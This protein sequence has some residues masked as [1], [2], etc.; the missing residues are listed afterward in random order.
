M[1]RSIHLSNNQLISKYNVIIII[2]IKMSTCMLYR[3]YHAQGQLTHN[4][5]RSRAPSINRGDVVSIQIDTN[6]GEINFFKNNLLIKT[7][8]NL[9]DT[10][11][12]SGEGTDAGLRPFVSFGKRRD[13]V[14]FMGARTGCHNLQY[15]PADPFTRVSFEGIIE[16][17]CFNG[18]GIL[19]YST[20][21]YWRGN[22]VSGKQ[23]G[24]Q[25]WVQQKA[26]LSAV[27]NESAFQQQVQSQVASP[28]NAVSADSTSDVV[29]QA[30]PIAA[31][32]PI[33][34][35][36]AFLFKN[37][38]QVRELPGSKEAWCEA[39]G[40]T[41]LNLTSI[42]SIRS[43]NLPSPQLSSSQPLRAVSN[44]SFGMSALFGESSPG[45]AVLAAQASDMTISSPAN[46]D[47][48]NSGSVKPAVVTTPNPF[49]SEPER[50]FQS[51][52]SRADEVLARITAMQIIDSENANTSQPQLTASSS[53]SS[54]ESLITSENPII[55]P[56]ES[57]DYDEFV[58]SQMETN[59]RYMFLFNSYKGG[60]GPTVSE[61]FTVAS[62]GRG[63]ILGSRGFSTGIHYWEVK[64]NLA[65]I[66]DSYG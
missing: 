1:V 46:I 2:L 21:G 32:T 24:I 62:H 38:E 43:N 64:L 66:N 4:S 17:G 18:P 48:V 37:G 20:P 5:H 27:N 29:A 22:W 54:S 14:I 11:C 34:T 23:H 42:G 7:F 26:S 12:L 31:V 25:L 49:A 30:S 56:S 41:D 44:E 60:N 50:W 40:F 51:E 33:F 19:R 45:A 59:P 6:E 57:P 63:M 55:H 53:T 9:R 47:A 39:L 10:G 15:D 61:D 3:A 8:S 35:V 52:K 36:S 65:G 16:N 58:F 13:S 28:F